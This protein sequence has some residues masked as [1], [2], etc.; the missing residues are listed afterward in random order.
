[1]SWEPNDYNYDPNYYDDSNDY[2][3]E[4]EDLEHNFMIDDM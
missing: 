2:D 3:T 4:Y 1:M